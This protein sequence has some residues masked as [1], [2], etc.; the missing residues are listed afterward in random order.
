MRRNGMSTPTLKIVAAVLAG[1]WTA[2]V[3]AEIYVCEDDDGVTSYQDQPCPEPEPAAEVED[4]AAG[5]NA[6][7]EKLPAPE[8][9][10]PADPELVA[11]CKKRYRDE[12][13]RLDA[14]LA[15]GVAPDKLEEYREQAR[16]LSQRLSR[17]EHGGT[18]TA[19]GGGRP[20]PAGR[21]L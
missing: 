12:I 17:C 21:D 9:A 3:S 14:E 7:R 16:A 6:T 8:A 13:D 2:D 15:S 20:E 1:W 10:E 18:N 5:R 11:A 19:S 4:T